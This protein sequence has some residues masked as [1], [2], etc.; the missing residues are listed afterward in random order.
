[1]LDRLLAA[2]YGPLTARA[3]AGALGALRAR[4]LFDVAGHVLVVGAGTGADLPHLPDTVS[5]VTLL[6]PSAAMRDR[7]ATAVPARLAQRTTVLDGF[8]ER[9]PLPDASVDHA[10]LSLVLCSVR[11]PAAAVADLHRVVR[12]GGTV[13]VVEHGAA[14]GERARAVQHRLDPLW[15]RLAGGCR[16]TRDPIA[17]LGDAFDVRDLAIVDVPGVQRIGPVRA[18]TA[19]R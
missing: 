10:V 3:E 6:E 8:A 14:R 9:L 4:L 15:R 5:R 17:L 13:R 1:L 16:L 18:G 19:R 11:D 7:L 2:A 12:P